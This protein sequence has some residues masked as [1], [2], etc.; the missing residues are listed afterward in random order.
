[1]SS[2]S[3]EVWNLSLKMIGP[4]SAPRLNAK[5]KES[6]GLLRFSVELLQKYA[7]K[8]KAEAPAVI[9]KGELLT[10]AGLAALKFDELL[11]SAE[12]R[13]NPKTQEAM[14]AAILRHSKLFCL[15]GGTLAPKHHV[16]IHLAQMCNFTGHPRTYH[17][18]HDEAVN[19]IIKVIAANSHRGTFAQTVLY[20]I[21]I[22]RLLGKASEQAH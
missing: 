1:M 16:M 12:T 2:V 17:T 21:H 22:L 20:K 3:Y 10:A 8:L 6:H 4:M 5:A 14:L 11:D 19:G 13:I 18:Y 7:M 15:A 9:L